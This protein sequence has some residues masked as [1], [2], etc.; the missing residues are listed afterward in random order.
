MFGKLE[1]TANINTS[2][3]GL[4]LSTCKKIAKAL[5]GKIFLVDEEQRNLRGKII[6]Y[7]D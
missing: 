5:D 7:D 4:G 1:S 3:L 2:G 6:D